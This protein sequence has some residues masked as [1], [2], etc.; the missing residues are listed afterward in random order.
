MGRY[1]VYVRPQAWKESKS[2][3]GNVRQRIRRAFDDLAREPRLA[4]TKAL[5]TKKTTLEVRR[6]RLADWRIVYTVNEELMQVQVLTIQ[7][8][9]P[10]DYGDLEKLL[11]D[12]E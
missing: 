10:Y 4:R 11:A 12:A 7:R 9:P 2:L 3:P 8:R 1:R 5:E 6:L